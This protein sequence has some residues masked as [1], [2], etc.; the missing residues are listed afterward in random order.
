M[1]PEILEHVSWNSV[2][3]MQNIK[4]LNN[5]IN[6][7]FDYI[8]PTEHGAYNS[9]GTS[10]KNA[11]GKVIKW[12]RIKDILKHIVDIAYQ[13][14][15]DRIGYNLYPMTTEKELVYASYKQEKK[16]NYDWHVD[17]CATHIFDTKL[18][19]ILNLSEDKYEGGVFEYIGAG[20]EIK[21]IDDFNEPGSMIIFKSY[22]NH[23]VLPVTKGQRNTL[24]LFL[25]GPK[26]C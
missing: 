17:S 13:C 19:M 6:E 8:E 11:D 9:D 25:N 7:N 12:F 20:G 1:R 18:T 2:F 26:L 21:S 14:N 16:G 24:T 15:N 5:Y 23:R 3:S 22:L 10:K 4:I